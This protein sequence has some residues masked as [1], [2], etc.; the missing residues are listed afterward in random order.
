LGRFLEGGG[1]SVPFEDKNATTALKTAKFISS[2]EGLHTTPYMDTESWAIC[3]GHRSHP[4]DKK[5]EEECWD[6][7]MTSA[8]IMNKYVTEIYE[9]DLNNNQIVALSSLHYNV[10]NPADVVWRANNGYSDTSIA[11]SINQ[12]TYAGGVQLRG[13]IKRRNAEAELFLQKN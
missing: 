13:L 4:N 9:K 6:M 10:K 8:E 1:M 12:Y 11:N 2:W 5:T 3:Y 7:M